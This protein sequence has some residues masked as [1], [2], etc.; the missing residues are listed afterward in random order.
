M[1]CPFNEDLIDLVQNSPALY[2]YNLPEFK[3]DEYKLSIWRE[4]AKQLEEEGKKV[5][6][7]ILSV[8]R[9]VILI[10]KPTTICLEYTSW[11]ESL[12]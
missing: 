11:S 4:I 9:W 12:L 3:S 6:N 7:F 2:N 5:A 1:V 10:L 8:Q